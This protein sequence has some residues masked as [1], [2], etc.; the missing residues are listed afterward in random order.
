VRTT[1]PYRVAILY[2]TGSAILGYLGVPGAP[3]PAWIPWVEYGPVAVLAA[4]GLWIQRRAGAGDQPA[5]GSA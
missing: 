2:L 5:D 4:A 1:N 3:V